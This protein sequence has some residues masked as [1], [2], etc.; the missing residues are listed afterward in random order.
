M[1]PVS[2]TNGFGMELNTVQRKGWVTQP[3]D[4]SRSRFRSVDHELMFT[5]FDGDQ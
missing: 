2:G 1:L 3:H 5:V 4:E